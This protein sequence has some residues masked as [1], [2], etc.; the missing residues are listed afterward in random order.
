MK[1]IYLTEEMNYSGRISI[2]C[3]ICQLCLA[4]SVGLR[5]EVICFQDYSIIPEELSKI[6]TLFGDEKFK[7]AK[8]DSALKTSLFHGICPAVR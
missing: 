8:A 3:Q 4:G 1:K 5:I 2:I 7:F 6:N